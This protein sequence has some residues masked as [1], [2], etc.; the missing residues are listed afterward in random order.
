MNSL[1]HTLSESILDKK[2]FIQPILP[3]DILKTFN[4]DVIKDCTITDHEIHI[5]PSA[6]GATIY[7]RPQNLICDITEFGITDLVIHGRRNNLY[8]YT[9]QYTPKKLLTIRGDDE[10]SLTDIY[11]FTSND[12]KRDV[13]SHITLQNIRLI[14]EWDVHV[15]QPL[16]SQSQV[17]VKSKV[18]K[19]YGAAVYEA[20]NSN[21]FQEAN[22]QTLILGVKG[23]DVKK[24]YNQLGIPPT[25]IK[26]FIN[27]ET[28]R[29]TE[30][31]GFIKA[32][33]GWMKFRDKFVEAFKKAKTL[34]PKNNPTI[35]T[36]HI[37]YNTASKVYQIIQ[38]IN[39]YNRDTPKI[40]SLG[41]LRGTVRRADFK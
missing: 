5:Y 15:A 13:D 17:C 24:I 41:I 11:L 32:S 18:L 35:K 12:L 21:V 3:E 14:A 39:I 38:D 30:S 6:P 26:A 40:D 28:E 29:Y 37:Y 23:K 10:I 19:I 22:F 25:G 27:K 1:H 36:I 31:S 9:A 8:L 4:S 34:N 16:T 7:W 20:L 2:T 33:P